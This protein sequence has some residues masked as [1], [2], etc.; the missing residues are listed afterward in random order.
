[1]DMVLAF[2][3][4]ILVALCKNLKKFINMNSFIHGIFS[5]FVTSLAIALAILWLDN[6]NVS[7]S[8][9]TIAAFMPLYPGTAVTNGI[10]DTL[11]GDYVAGIARITDAVVI[12]T[13]L[14]IG[15]ALAIAV[16]G[17]IFGWH[18]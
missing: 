2:F 15:V 3:A 1:M 11:K 13:S 17:V 10:R 8:I 6:P 12:A 9:V 5:T 4:G 18:I 16:Y 14:A 7:R